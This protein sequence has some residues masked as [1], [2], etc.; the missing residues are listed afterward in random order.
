MT[1]RLLI[2]CL[3]LMMIFAG[4]SSKT[5]APAAPAPAAEAPAAEPAP[6]AAAAEPAKNE[7]LTV[8]ITA[9]PGGLDPSH[10]SGSA[11]GQVIR[12][13]YDTLFIYDENYTITPWLAE[14]YEYEDDVTLVLHLRHGVK[15]AN[16]DELHASD[17][18]FTI[19]TAQA[20]TGASD[21]F[22]KINVEKSVVVDDY[23]IKLVTDEPV[24][25]LIAGLQLPDTG[26]F[27]EKAYTEANGDFLQ[28]AKTG[29]SGPWKL[30]VYTPGDKITMTANE[31]YWREGEPYFKTLVMR[32]VTDASSRAIE[33]ETAGADIVCNIASKDIASVKEAKGM[34]FVSEKGA[35]TVYL[36]IN[37]Q[38]APMDNDLVRQA[39]WYAVDVDSGVRVAYGDFGSRAVDWVCPGI[40]GADPDRAAKYFPT[41]DIEKAK[42]LLAEAGYPDGIEIELSVFSSNQERRDLGEIF[43]AQ[44]AEAGI[45][46]KLNVM[47][48]NAWSDYVYAGNSHMVFYA[49]TGMCF[50]ADKCL[51]Q[52]I[53]SSSYFKVSGFAPEAYTAAVDKSLTALDETERCALYSEAI[54]MLLENHVTLPCWHNELNASVREG[55]TGF[56]INRSYEHH[57]LQFVRPAA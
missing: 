12:Q 50:E 20:G 45:K 21:S 8:V 6:A 1:K 5:P 51:T 15:F 32:F 22:R 42:A 30:D 47:E 52:L 3:A 19:K 43:Q 39:V 7:T 14:S 54:N 33:A 28:L 53:P 25:T 29:S 16:N 9:D 46:V 17:V 41:R 23:T 27:S 35:Q 26:I 36:I 2:L 11:M 49:C 13:M 48:L 44:M 55:L 31:N 38:K 18:L 40:K 10:S 4:C 24:A 57:L 37:T 56:R 34:V